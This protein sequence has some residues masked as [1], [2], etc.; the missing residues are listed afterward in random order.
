ML[1]FVLELLQAVLGEG[2]K[3]SDALVGVSLRIANL[4]RFK[5]GEIV[6]LRGRG[7]GGWRYGWDERTQ[8]EKP[9]S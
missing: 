8:E 7:A 9:N 5:S 2:E 1:Q 3:K 4:V 6:L